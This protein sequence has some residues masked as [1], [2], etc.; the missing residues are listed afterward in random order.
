M[1]KITSEVN[2]NV[3]E[4]PETKKDCLII[5]ILLDG[6]E[7]TLYTKDIEEYKSIQT[8]TN[9][10]YGDILHTSFVEAVRN[11]KGEKAFKSKA[12]LRELK[13]LKTLIESTL[14]EFEQEYLQ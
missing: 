12:V 7:L 2:W 1:K 4:N 13:S 14:T 3:T 8:K 11:K 5:Q 9:H 6:V 10:R